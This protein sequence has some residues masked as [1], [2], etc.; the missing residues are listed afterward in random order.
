[1]A[2]TADD[3]DPWLMV[4]LGGTFDIERVLIY[5]RQDCCQN[6]LSNARITLFNVNGNV[7]TEFSNIGDTSN[8]KIIER[9]MPGEYECIHAFNPRDIGSVGMP[10]RVIPSANG[11]FQILGSGSGKYS[12]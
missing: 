6:G 12:P 11:T 4:D 10:G 1:L 8:L 2:H 7:I 5:N 3:N 9:V